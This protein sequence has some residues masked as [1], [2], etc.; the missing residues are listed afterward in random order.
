MPVCKAVSTTITISP[1]NYLMLPCFH[2]CIKK[3]K[4]ND[5][6]ADLYN[7][8]EVQEI[9]KMEGRFEFCKGCTN[10]CYMWVSLHNNILSRYFYISLI[11]V[12]KHLRERGAYQFFS[13]IKLFL[14]GIK[15]FIYETY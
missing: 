15:R 6:L 10:T 1:D 11:S 7:S 9:K 2:K 5:N 8:G 12:I 4:I 13:E 3:I 14:S